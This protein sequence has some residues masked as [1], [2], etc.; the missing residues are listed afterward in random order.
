MAPG[1]AEQSFGRIE[2]TAQAVQLALLIARPPDHDLGARRQMIARPGRRIEGAGPVA[3]RLQDL[4]T[5]DQALAAK[6]R[7][8]RLRGAPGVELPRPLVRPREIEDS[9]AGQ[10]DGAIDDSRQHRR[11]LARRDPEHRLVQP[12][13]AFGELV[14]HDQCLA[15]AEQAER[16]QV[17]IVEPLGEPD[18]DS[19]NFV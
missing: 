12:G 1:V 8:V 15:L 10:D 5:V 18:R 16:Q 6:R 3:A 7:E 19:Y 17:G 2:F 14:L 13:G 4:R 9:V 11:D